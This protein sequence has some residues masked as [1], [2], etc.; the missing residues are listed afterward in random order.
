MPSAALLNIQGP[1]EQNH[2]FLGYCRALADSGL[3]FLPELVGYAHSSPENAGLAL[4]KMFYL[5][6]KPDAVFCFNDELA[7]GVYRQAT[8]MNLRI[9]DDLAVI[10]VDNTRF[11]RVSLRL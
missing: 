2:G 3:P 1:P 9:P 8:S 11:G 5:G 10:G 6:H 4:E 7:L